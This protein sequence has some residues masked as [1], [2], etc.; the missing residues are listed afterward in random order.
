VL[1]YGPQAAVLEP[2]E[3]RLEIVRRLQAIL[4]RHA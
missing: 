1:Q 2:E 4:E 3:I